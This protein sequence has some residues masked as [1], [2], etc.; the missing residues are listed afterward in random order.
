M[1][2][3]SQMEQSMKIAF[4]I[5]RKVV[6]HLFQ[7]WA[8]TTR[9]LGAIYMSYFIPGW[10]S[11]RDDLHLIPGWLSSRCL[12]IYVWVFTWFGAKMCSPRDDFIPVFSTGMKSSRGEPIFAPNHV[13]AYR[14]DQTPRWKSSRD[15][16]KVIPGWNNSCKQRLTMPRV[17]DATVIKCVANI[18]K[19]AFIAAAFILNHMQF[20]S[21]Q[22]WCTY[23]QKILPSVFQD[24]SL[25]TAKWTRRQAYVF[26]TINND[27]YLYFK[28]G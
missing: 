15:E 10:V 11:P 14:F 25:Q 22:L 21:W 8:T 1:H 9:V 3:W 17:Q 28:N 24:M 6:I 12:V 5:N 18:I 20:G 4:H 2:S 16:M 23:N 13:N 26:K 7:L 19:T 27:S